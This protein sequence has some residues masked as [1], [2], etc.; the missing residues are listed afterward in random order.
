M[1]KVREVNMFML[2]MK[3]RNSFINKYWFMMERWGKGS[4]NLFCLKVL[5][6]IVIMGG[7]DKKN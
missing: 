1:D 2:K 6:V 7:Y 5:M 3:G 4:W